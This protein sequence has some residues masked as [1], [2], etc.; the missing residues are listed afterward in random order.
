MTKPKKQLQNMIEELKRESLL[1]Q[2]VVVECKD[3][4]KDYDCY[5]VLTETNNVQTFRLHT[6]SD[7]CKDYLAKYREL[8]EQPHLTS[9]SAV[10]DAAK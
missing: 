10:A 6:H 4:G 1:R 5:S 7:Q 3:C 2:V 8:E 9:A